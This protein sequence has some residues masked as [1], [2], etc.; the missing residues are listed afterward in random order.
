MSEVKRFY[1]LFDE[2]K[3]FVA[4]GRGFAV[5]LILKGRFAR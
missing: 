5:G 2:Q 1:R 3:E 4:V